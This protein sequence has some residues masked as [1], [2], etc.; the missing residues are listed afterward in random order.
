MTRT[1][2]WGASEAR[3]E[4]ALRLPPDTRRKARGLV[5]GQANSK[6]SGYTSPQENMTQN[7]RKLSSGRL[8]RGSSSLPGKWL[9]QALDRVFRDGLSDGAAERTPAVSATVAAGKRFPETV[10]P[11]AILHA[12][13]SPRVIPVP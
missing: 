9:T 4:W 5:S 2:G 10:Y 1:G 11:H 12:G 8:S 7:S 13:D 6:P 3:D